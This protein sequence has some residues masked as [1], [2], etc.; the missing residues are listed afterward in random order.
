[1]G[2]QLNF[3]LVGQLVDLCQREKVCDASCQIAN[4]EISEL[5]EVVKKWWDMESYGTLIFADQRT[6][7]DKI[8]DNH[9]NSTVNFEETVTK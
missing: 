5:A 8:A 3:H 7:E 9:W 4:P 1:M 2:S 6:H